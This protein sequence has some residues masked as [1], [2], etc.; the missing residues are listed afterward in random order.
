MNELKQ[1]LNVKTT[2]IR[3][4]S[5]ADKKMLVEKLTRDLMNWITVNCKNVIKIIKL[6]NKNI[7]IIM[8]SF[9]IKKFLKKNITWIINICESIK[10]KIKIYVVCIINMMINDVM[11]NTK[12]IHH[13][14]KK[15]ENVYSKLKIVRM[16]WLKLVIKWNKLKTTLRLKIENV[17]II[18]QLICKNLINKYE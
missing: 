12:Q 3:I 15:N 7:K 6:Q 4:N 16:S 10:I 11:T 2:T 5:D 9:Q 18:N 14:E 17:K 8:K 1:T 13:I